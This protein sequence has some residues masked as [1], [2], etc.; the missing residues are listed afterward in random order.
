MI[1]SSIAHLFLAYQGLKNKKKTAPEFFVRTFDS[2]KWSPFCALQL[3]NLLQCL[4]CS[5][6][7]FEAL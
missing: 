2:R 6:A 5:Q 4:I 1:L 7:A 3:N